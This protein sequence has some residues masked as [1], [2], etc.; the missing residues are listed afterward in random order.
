MTALLTKDNITKIVPWNIPVPF[1]PQIY[2]NHVNDIVETY[3][4]HSVDGLI[5]K[6]N[7][8]KEESYYSLDH[9]SKDK[10]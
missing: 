10:L 1:F 5:G 2:Y 8:V 3:V 7:F 4:L 6:Y 9:Q